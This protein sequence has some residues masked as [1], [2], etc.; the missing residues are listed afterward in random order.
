MNGIAVFL[1]NY[2][3]TKSYGPE[4]GIPSE[5]D[6]EPVD[7]IV[8]GIKHLIYEG[9]ADAKKLAISGHSHGG[10]LAPLVMTRHRIFRAASFADGTAN[11]F[12]GYAMMPGLV[13]RFTHDQV[14]FEGDDLYSSVE[15]AVEVSPVFHFQGL[16]TAVLFEAGVESLAV[17]MLDHVKAARLAG[18][19]TEYIVYPKT[20]HSLR[21]PTLQKESA[22]RNLDWLMFWLNDAEDPNPVK[23]DQYM[24]WRAM[25]NSSFVEKNK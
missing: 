24:R 2:R 20:F 7:D 9:V 19:P 12:V 15:R 10:W 11:M 4:I 13:N 3:G 1:P 17:A 22:E 14:F 16:E 18:M 25:P 8:S 21:I 6:G 5:I 23:Q